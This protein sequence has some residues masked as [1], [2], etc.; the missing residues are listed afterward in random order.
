MHR[1]SQPASQSE[2]SHPTA[3][4]ERRADHSNLPTLE[5]PA[6]TS[7]TADEWQGMTIDESQPVCDTSERCGL[8]T[9]CIAG[10]CGGCTADQDCASG[11]A[12][13]LD[14]CVRSDLVACRSRTECK[15]GELCVLSGVSPDARGNSDMR[16][17]C[18]GSKVEIAP[19]PR[20]I[21]GEPACTCG[22]CCTT[23]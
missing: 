8:A 9:A 14:H 12:C 16:A 23:T 3:L 13:V 20:G 4:D 17:Y 11:E 10:R 15:D 2:T 7:R 6:A 22:D 19:E 5:V 18:Q 21:R 1:G